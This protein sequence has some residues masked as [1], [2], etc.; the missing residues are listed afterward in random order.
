[1]RDKMSQH[2]IKR[3]SCGKQF[4][5]VLR[6]ITLFYYYCTTYSTTCYL[7]NIRGAGRRILLL[8]GLVEFLVFM[9]S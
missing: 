2:N 3:W 6:F 5:L 4:N 9:L 8:F 1:M 7:V